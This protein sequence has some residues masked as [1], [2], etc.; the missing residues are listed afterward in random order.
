[1]DSINLFFRIGAVPLIYLMILLTL[2]LAM[3]GK[4]M[5]KKAFLLVIL[6]LPI[7]VLLIK[8]IHLFFYE[9][10][11][12]VTYNFTPMVNEAADASFPSRH[13]AISAVIAFS[14]MYFKSKWSLLFLFAAAWIGLARIY[15]GVHYPL[16]IIGGFLVGLVSLVISIQIKNLLRAGFLKKSL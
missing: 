5:E 2:V 16:D 7:A 12:F 10:R 14:Y 4:A 6:A 15:V 13:A 8:G 11:P 1:M 9:P 3:K